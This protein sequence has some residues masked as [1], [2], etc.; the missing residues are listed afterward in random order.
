[1][2]ATG[3]I[4]GVGTPCDNCFGCPGEVSHASGVYR[5]D[6]CGASIWLPYDANQPGMQATVPISS[7]PKEFRMDWR[8]PW[9]R[10]S[11]EYVDGLGIDDY[12]YGN[13]ELRVC[14]REFGTST[15]GDVSVVTL[16][17]F[18]ASASFTLNNC[19]TCSNFPRGTLQQI[20]CGGYLAGGFVRDSSTTSNYKICPTV[21][22]NLPAVRV[23]VLSALYECNVWRAIKYRVAPYYKITYQASTAHWGTDTYTL[24]PILCGSFP[25]R[26]NFPL[27]TDAQYA[28]ALASYNN[29]KASINTTPQVT[30]ITQAEQACGASTTLTLAQIVGGTASYWVNANVLV[31]GVVDPI[32]SPWIPINQASDLETT[33]NVG[34]APVLSGVSSS[35]IQTAWNAANPTCW[36]WVHSGG[37][38][39]M[40]VYLAS[41]S[42]PFSIGFPGTMIGQFN[43]DPVA[44]KL[45]LCNIPA[46]NCG[47]TRCFS[48]TELPFPE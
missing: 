47:S 29:C 26:S 1:M 21:R 48:D 10:K 25:P 2:I 44:V 4:G 5:F 43:W 22:I 15:T 37:R 18:T 16:P 33:R 24:T 14:E 38:S 9:A 7:N 28:A 35:A 30:T 40:I 34:S 11:D 41:A 12:D 3:N 31:G 20:R 23:Q 6:A 13:R 46:N 39:G 42:P 45:R 36:D 27:A 19:V 32:Y 17:P 8:S